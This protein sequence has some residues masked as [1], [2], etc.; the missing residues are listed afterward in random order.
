[1]NHEITRRGLLKLSGAATAALAGANW[2]FR[3]T[4]DG[5][6]VKAQTGNTA[7]FKPMFFS[8]AQVLQLAAVC[9]TI[10][11]RTDTPGARDARVHEYIDVAMTVE[12]EAVSKRFRDGLVWL[13][14]QCKKNAR[15]S[16][17][18]ASPEQL[19]AL[20]SSISD[21]N[22]DIAVERKSGAAF[23]TDL[24]ARTIFGYYT[25]REGWVEEL[26]L[27]E[28]VGMEKFTGCTHDGAH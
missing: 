17:A 13:E 16:L 12:S 21:D 11:P 27:P 10:I 15:K 4:N 25:S 23:F 5:R 22:P 14:A 6:V 9:E 20:L 24:K 7:A 19:V 1:M 28:H 3:A 2:I 26:G 8:E 18:E